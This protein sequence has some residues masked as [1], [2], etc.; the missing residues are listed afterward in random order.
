[1]IRSLAALTVVATLVSTFSAWF[2]DQLGNGIAFI[3][4]GSTTAVFIALVFAAIPAGIYWTVKRRLMPG[5]VRAVWWIWGLI[6][7][8]VF[9]GNSTNVAT[10]QAIDSSIAESKF[11]LASA[12][13]DFDDTRK[14]AEEGVA[15]AQVVMGD[16]YRDP[17]NFGEVLVID[18]VQGKR[19][20]R[21]LSDAGFSQDFNKAFEWYQKAASNGLAEAQYKLGMLF[22]NGDGVPKD[23]GK[24]FEWYL[25]AAMQGH[26]GAQAELGHSYEYGI[27]VSKDSAK[28]VWWYQK[29]VAQNNVEAEKALGWAYLGG[30]SLVPKNEAKGIEL[31]LKAASQGDDSAQ[32]LIGLQYMRG[33]FLD[34]DLV[35]AYAWMLLSSAQKNLEATKYVDQIEAELSSTQRREGQR[36]AAEWKIGDTLLPTS[37]ADVG[38]EYPIKKLT[39]QSTGT[40]FAVS[41]D[42]HALTNYHV[43]NRCREVKIS[44]QEDFAKVI[45]SDVVNDLALLQISGKFNA[46]AHLSSEVDALRQGEDLAVFGYP[47]NSLL[48][49][50]GN[51]T[52]G[53]LSALAGLGN[54]TNQIQITAPI[55]PGSSGSPVMDK[56]GNVIG[57][58][59]MK[60]NDVEMARSTGSVGQNVNFAV[61]GQTVKAFLNANNVSYKTGGGCLIV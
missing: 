33:D 54:N 13:I 28:A 45:A 23:S 7:F 25:K 41:F 3:L 12:V 2:F 42:G 34:K 39:K 9:V 22:G 50:G 51:F 59:S 14:K 48:S 30:Y 8:A 49:A 58:V 52:P 26:A 17:K 32:G 60:L 5:F 47:L 46:V 35:R 55:Q 38:T 15:E 43:V 56:K 29:A 27:G 11:D 57:I 36:L 16:A 10:P 24:A 31:I 44:G 6:A 20:R 21:N 37:S 4:G 61:N 18:T 19:I 40:A 53:T 1:M